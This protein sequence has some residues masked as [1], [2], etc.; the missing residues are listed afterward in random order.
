MK[1]LFRLFALT[2]FALFSQTSWT[3]APQQMSYQS[4]VRNA[5]GQLV[6][7]QAVGLKISVLQGSVTGTVVFAETHNIITNTNG[8]VSIEIGGGATQSGDFSM[9]NWGNGP[10]FIKTEIDPNGGSNYTIMGTS[11]LLSVPYAFYAEHTKS[12]GKTSIYLTGD[13]TDAEAAVKLAQE[14]GPFTENIY[15]LKTTQ[16]TTV[17]LSN[18]TTLVNLEVL[19]N[20]ALTTL[21]LNFTNIYGNLH[22]NN[23]PI[24]AQFSFPNL[25]GIYGDLSINNNPAITQFTLPSLEEIYGT[26]TITTNPSLQT[27]GL[28][29]LKYCR[30]LISVNN[31]SSL[32]AVD[33]PALVNVN[34]NIGISNNI[35][36]TA[37]NFSMLQ[38]FSQDPESSSPSGLSIRG[39]NAL[40]TLNLPALTVIAN[41]RLDV[42]GSIATL[43]IPVLQFAEVTV[44]YSTLSLFNA[45]SLTNSILKIT[46]NATLTSLN[47]PLLSQSAF[48]VTNNATLSS[49]SIPSY[50]AL[51]AGFNSLYFKDNNLPTTQ[52]NYLL[53][54]I[55]TITPTSG[56]SILLKQIPA[57]PPTGQGLIDKAALISAG[58]TV[59]T[60]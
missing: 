13:I 23:N 52:V 55:L 34:G 14:A 51:N 3:Q 26:A 16:L 10:Y 48:E 22:I 57:A 24:L 60:N 1:S 18:L 56:K 31:N 35:S 46:N 42:S 15:I 41:G 54:K 17:N 8:L 25:E 36:L 28:P 9:I 4:V 49:I 5:S 27:F 11:Q 53:S 44:N 20:S 45:P 19:N 37:I 50:S 30:G 12:L 29:G 40:N 33:L 58:N 47:L 43:N 6:A 32:A 21:N 39:N 38:T 7:N 2:I 59:E